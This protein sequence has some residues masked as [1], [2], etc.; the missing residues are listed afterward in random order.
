[1]LQSMSASPSPDESNGPDEPGLLVVG[2]A[3]FDGA[4]RLLA[5]QRRAPRSYAG[6]W[7]FPGGKVEEEESPVA[8]LIRECREELNIDVDVDDLVGEVPIPIGRLRVY[9]ARITGGRLLL[10]EHSAVRW[11]GPYELD[12]VPW[13]GAD[14]PLVQLLSRKP[15]P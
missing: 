12:A 11:L 7:E 14:W 4:H 2:A 1:M 15:L 3:I 10:R 9:R 5:A 8:A 6:L 13:I